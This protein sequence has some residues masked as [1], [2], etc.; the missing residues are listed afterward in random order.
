MQH[1]VRLADYRRRRSRVYFTRAELSQLLALY[2]RRV[3][4]GEWR[5]YAIDHAVGI[6]VFSV[7]RHTFDRPACVITKL[8]GPGGTTFAVFDGRGRITS[9]T[10]LAEVLPVVEHR[11]RL[12]TD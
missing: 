5:D 9:G 1:V 8:T 7:F 12:V 11:P 4:G 10:S 2:S 6:A 3:A